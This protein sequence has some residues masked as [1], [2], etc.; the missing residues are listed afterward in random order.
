MW[1]HRSKIL[2]PLSS[3]T[4][5]QAKWHWSKESQKVFDT[6]H[7]FISRETLLPYPNF[8]KSFEIY[9]DKSTL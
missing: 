8:N 9:K 6:T 2:S 5:K 1:Q 3:M 7:D 4:S